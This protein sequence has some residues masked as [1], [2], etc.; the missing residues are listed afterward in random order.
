MDKKSKIIIAG[1][2]GAGLLLGGRFLGHQLTKYIGKVL[3]TDSYN[4][5]LLELISATQSVGIRNIWETELRA[6]T[7]SVIQRPLGS[8]KKQLNFDGLAFNPV[9]LKRLPTASTIRVDTET[10]IGKHCKKPLLISTPIIIS[11][12]AYGLALCKQAKYALASGS[13]IA[14]TAT[15]TGEGLWLQ[16][17]RD[18]AK[19][20]IIQY[21]RGTWSK[22]PEILSQADMIEIQLGQGALTGISHAV[23]GS[24]LTPEVKSKLDT[25]SKK[26]V[27]SSYHPI[28]DQPEGLKKLVSWLKSITSGIPIG[29]KLSFN[30]CIEVEIDHAIDAGI[31]V[32]ALEGSQSASK[33]APPILQDEFGLPT[34]IGLCRTVEHLEKRNLKDKIDLIVGG[35]LYTPGD[36][37]KALALGADAV[38]I[39]SIA[40]F[41]MTHTQVLKALPFEPPTQ[42][43]WETGKYK[44][45]FNWHQGAKSVAK[46]L[47]SCT[48]EMSE[49]VRALGKTAITQ[50]NRLD[51]VALEETTAAVTGI[52][53]AWQPKN[54][55]RHPSRNPSR[56]RYKR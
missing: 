51:L 11:G 48:L 10:V 29:I 50:V 18:L 25:L 9:Y 31:D 6:E 34:L 14:G 7:G 19:N 27:I 52:P 17:E 38:Y 16:R 2:T 53:L 3:M 40:L 54:E 39:G 46:F 55:N 15:N 21:N 12:M 22:D 36:F 35:G 1:L 5:N 45:R 20:L 43:I 30:N 4:E 47:K 32:L 24:S 8:P 23:E 28:F 42:V 26:A 33:G 49:A 44:H 13:A 56:L 41:A 37:L